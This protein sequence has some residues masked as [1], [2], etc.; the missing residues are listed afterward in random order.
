MSRAQH[1]W[2][3]LT[4]LALATLTWFALLVTPDGRIPVLLHDGVTTLFGQSALLVPLGFTLATLILLA[5]LVA[6]GLRVPTRQLVGLVVLALGFLPAEHLLRLGFDAAAT[7][8]RSADGSGIVGYWIAGT[9]LRAMG[10]AGTVLVI[11]GLLVVGALFTLRFNPTKLRGVRTYA[12][13][14]PGQLRQP[15][16]P[17][18][19]EFAEV[20]TE[21]SST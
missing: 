4:C 1:A 18:H 15:V 5:G 10:S 2:L 9:L 7:A 14:P 19:R 20:E 11:I 3:A 17:P 16:P 12:S 6:P 13:V 8:D 21:V